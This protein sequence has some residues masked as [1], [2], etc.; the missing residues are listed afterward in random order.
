MRRGQVVLVDTNIIIEAVRSRC[1]NALVTHFRVETVEKCLEEALTGDPLRRSYVEVDARSVKTGLAQTHKVMAIH[2]A[3]FV[4][5]LPM[6]DE[7]DAGERE[8]FAHALSRNDEWLACCADRAALK[9]AFT[10]GWMDRMVSLEQLANLAGAQPALKHH[11]GKRWLA[12][13]RTAFL[14]EQGLP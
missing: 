14:L 2:A 4:V 11:F 5:A 9:A 3:R 1:W 6:A 13:V 8:L 12:D 7:L 10:L